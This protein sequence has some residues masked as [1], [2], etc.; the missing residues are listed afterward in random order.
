MAGLLFFAHVLLHA[1][2]IALTKAAYMIAVKRLSVIFGLVYG[3]LVF[4][5]KNI[6]MRT[7]GTL[8]MVAG[9]VMITIWGK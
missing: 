6:A 9:A 5:E 3:G 4:Q 2:A 7:L 8:L 1:F